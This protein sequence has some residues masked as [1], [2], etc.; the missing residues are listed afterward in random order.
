MGLIDSHTHLDR[1]A[2]TGELPDVLA[3]AGAVGV[4][5]MIA[6]GTEPDDWTLYREMAET[7]SG[8]VHYTVGLH[9]CSVDEHWRSAVARL[10]RWRDNAG[11]MPVAIGETGLDRFHLPKN[12]AAAAD[13][14]LAWQRESFRA[15][16][17]L[18][19]SWSLPVVVHSRGAFTDCVAEIDASGFDW[20]RVV[21]HCFTDGPDEIAELNRRGGRGS[22]TGILTYKSAENVRQAALAQGLERVMVET[23]APYLTPEPLPRKSRNE[24]AFVVHTAAALARMFGISPEEFGGRSTANARSF[25]GL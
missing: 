10:E 24:P 8:T 4:E 19:Q 1:F 14:L 11:P 22:F 2:R 18:A 13:R 9:P 17:A 25:F 16:L 3:R 7:H 6:I 23:D 20:R 12:D 5:A 15:H 21:F